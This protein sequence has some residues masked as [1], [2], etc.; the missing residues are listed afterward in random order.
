M[1]EIYRGWYWRQVDHGGGWPYIYIYKLH[2]MNSLLFDLVYPVPFLDPFAC[3]VRYALQNVNVHRD[4][5]EQQKSTKVAVMQFTN[6]SQLK[7]NP[8][9]QT[10]YF[11][12]ALQSRVRALNT[13]SWAVSSPNLRTNK[14]TDSSSSAASAPAHRCCS[15]QGTQSFQGTTSKLALSQG[16]LVSIFAGLLDHEASKDHCASHVEK[17]AWSWTLHHLEQGDIFIP[18]V[19]TTKTSRIGVEDQHCLDWQYRNLTTKNWSVCHRC[20]FLTYRSAC[21]PV[22]KN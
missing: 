13:Q 22:G 5:T 3:S 10:Y 1:S 15:W 19:Q 18:L 16:G 11:Y 21:F 14:R 20:Y 2:G 4:L 17:C 6:L 12:W 9:R 8:I 7:W